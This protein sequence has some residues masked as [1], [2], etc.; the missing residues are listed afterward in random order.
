MPRLRQACMWRAHT[1]KSCCPSR[2][3]TALCLPPRRALGV[4][5]HV[6]LGT[7]AVLGCRRFL[8][9]GVG[10]IAWV[11]AAVVCYLPGLQQQPLRRPRRPPLLDVMP[12]FHNRPQL[13]PSQGACLVARLSLC[14][15]PPSSQ[16]HRPCGGA[17]QLA[18][19]PC[20]LYGTC[21]MVRHGGSRS[22]TAASL[23]LILTLS[24]EPSTFAL[25]VTARVNGWCRRRGRGAGAAAG[26]GDAG[27]AAV[28]RRA[29]PGA[30]PSPFSSSPDLPGLPFLAALRASLLK[31]ERVIKKGERGKTE[32]TCWE[33]GGGGAEDL[34]DCWQ[35]RCRISTR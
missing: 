10:G 6:P 2:L 21:V 16:Q 32:D 26:A 20:V 28:S 3:H 12:R 33:R 22:G 8:T 30:L 18:G 1:S 11:V 5:R 4:R 35:C 23:A 29:L 24:L 7:R 14:L 19:R 34:A 17:A 25:R 31:Q 15:E 13:A 9:A 27:C